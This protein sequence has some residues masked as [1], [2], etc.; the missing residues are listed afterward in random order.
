MTVAPQRQGPEPEAPARKPARSPAADR[1]LRGLGRLMVVVYF[2]AGLGYL[3]LRHLVWPNPDYW[4]PRV[5]QALSDAIGQPVSVASVRTGFDG[6]RPW[7]EA[8]DV[9]ILDDDG[10][11]AFRTSRVQAA[12]S[13]SGLAT[14][15]L[16]FARLDIQAPALRVERLDRRRLKVAGIVIDLAGATATGQSAG[17]AWLLDQRRIVLHAA[18]LDW[19]D[20][21]SG[22]VRRLTKVDLALGSVGR[23]HRASLHV[24]DAGE[25][26]RDLDA[27]IEVWRPA[28]SRVD[29][30]RAW[31]GRM[32]L[33][34]GRAELAPIASL[35]E[36]LRD[37]FASAA[38][39]PAQGAPAQSAP[40]QGAP[41]QGAPEQG[42]PEPG[43]P[44][45]G[46]P[47]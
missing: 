40:E 22:R 38:S 42:A 32:Y 6:L 20:R 14:G 11:V 27:A 28:W 25:F 21:V 7:F 3:A 43:A 26:G 41:E 33:A 19:I 34:A 8:R 17:S 16:Q 12:L 45:Q 29:D 9:A 1:L 46:A 35:A 2:V 39:A 13:L 15:R 23:R 36:D 4:F 47:E 37:L 30:W 5:E 10:S 24:V 44:E 18:D 31:T